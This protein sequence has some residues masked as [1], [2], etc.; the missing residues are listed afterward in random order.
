MSAADALAR[1]LRAL[2]VPGRDI[3]AEEDERA[4]RYR[5]MLAG[6]RILVFL[7]NAGSAEQVRPLLPGTPTCAVVTTSRDSLAGLVARDGAAR[8][9][10]GLLPEEAAVSLLGA[11][12]GGR[13]R[14]E[15]AV[16]RALADQ[17]ARLPL[18]LRVA[19]ELV[20][21]RPA[22]RLADLADE[23]ADQQ[24]RLS[25]LTADGDPRAAV[26]AVFSW[27]Y[28]HL[29]SAA[30]RAF[31]LAGLHPGPSLDA[32]AAAALIGTTVDQAADLLE[33]LARAYLMRQVTPG[34]Y[35]MHDL[36]HAYAAEQ[37]AAVDAE[38]NR[39]QALTGL[40]DHYLR[41]AAAAI[42]TLFPADTARRAGTPPPGGVIPPVAD[43]GAAR[44]WLDAHRAT[45]VAV[46]AYTADHGWP[47]HATRLATT[48]FRYLQGGGHLPEITAVYSHAR[49]AAGRTGD[50]SAAAEA[51]NCLCLVDLRQGRYQQAA[52][53][54]TKALTLYQQA[55]NRTG[56]A[57]ALGNLGIVEF[58][59]GRYEQ[60]I[61]Y[62]QQALV[63]YRQIRDR[64]G[65]ARTL[66]NL[67]LVDLRQGRY[68]QATGYLRQSLDLGR[69]TGNQA[70]EARALNNLGLVDLQQGRY[71][72]AAG[73]LRQS[74]D[75]CR[76]TGDMAG[77]AEALTS[78][79]TLDL[80]QDRYDQASGHLRRAL[81]LFRDIGDRSGEAKALTGL[82][83]ISLAAGRAARARAQ[84]ATAL[85]LA[86]Q[87]GDKYEKARAAAGLARSCQA[88]GDSVQA[89]G[90]WRQALALYASLGAPEAD[91][92][93]AQLSAA[94]P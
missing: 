47:G 48:M 72:Q 69:R 16:A 90:H 75:L 30:A 21:A 9:D 85:D 88:V 94:R 24:Q 58:Q 82:G 55:G 74:L 49:R 77:E 59:L 3:P 92:L 2:G 1:F 14:T 67:G 62:Q 25:L 12:I 68:E 39:Q 56:Q 17:C 33:Q 42:D 40:F 81:G 79:G 38:P 15:P 70:T 27:S 84:C 29:D 45:L 23:L 80:R 4:A 61:D 10:L 18:A 28:R 11:L 73:H 8:L 13:V 78:L 31:R 34:R 46:A 35:G 43:P 37:A 41:A 50:S 6:R 91:Q 32:Y 83:S 93:R 71:D 53:L 7:D 20:A 65:K 51:N 64:A 54:L 87:I 63:L 86:S 36:L 66:N 89:D 5:S 52:S 22:A 19:A 57:R 60:A 26:R 76:Q 44:A